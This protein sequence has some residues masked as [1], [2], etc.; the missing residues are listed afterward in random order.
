MLKLADDGP[1]S[2]AWLR[3]TERAHA[4]LDAALLTY[5]YARDDVAH[6]DLHVS[7][8]RLGEP[9]TVEIEIELPP[10]R[11][12]AIK[13]GHPVT[14]YAVEIDSVVHEVKALPG[15]YKAQRIVLPKPTP[16]P[17]NTAFDASELVPPAAVDSH[18]SLLVDGSLSS[19]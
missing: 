12:L 7:P 3:F 14:D 19:P 10:T 17:G 2:G 9:A 13:S 1:Q 4:G 8:L 6:Y 15:N 5:G 16:A 11:S 18:T